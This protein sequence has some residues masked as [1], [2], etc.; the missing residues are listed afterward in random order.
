MVLGLE[1]TSALARLY[2]HCYANLER[3]TLLVGPPYDARLGDYNYPRRRSLA[4]QGCSLCTPH[5]SQH[6][7]YVWH[8]NAPNRGSILRVVHFDPTY[9]HSSPYHDPPLQD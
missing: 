1:Q 7:A 5:E 6:P 8:L 9:V 4:L 2:G 3:R